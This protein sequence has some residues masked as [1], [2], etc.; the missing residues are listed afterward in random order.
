[1]RGGLCDAS[2]T[3]SCLAGTKRE[4]GIEMAKRQWECYET[5]TQTIFLQGIWRRGC[6]MLMGFVLACR[7]KERAR[8]GLEEHRLGFGNCL[9]FK[10]R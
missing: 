5:L 4:V 7:G 6:A 2:G 8:S 3:C 9:R 10:M 1:M